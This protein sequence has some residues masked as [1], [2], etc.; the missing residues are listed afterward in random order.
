MK[1]KFF[2]LAA[3]IYSSHLHA[4]DSLST[5]ALD[6]V[7]VTAN[8]S[9]QKQS[10]TGKVISIISKT[11]IEKS[12]ARTLA[13]LLNDQAGITINGSL[14]NLGSNQTLYMRGAGQGRTLVLVDGVPVYDPS[15]ITSEFDLNLISLNE[16]ERV[17][18]C[19]GAQSTLY[20]SDA[21][22]GVINIITVNN[23]VTRAINTRAGI[24]FGNY[25]A[26]RANAQV[27]GKKNK[28]EYYARYSSLRNTGFSSAYDSTGNNNFDNDAYRGQAASAGIRYEL[29]K[30]LSARGYIQYSKYKNDLDAT[31]FTDEKDQTV[32]NRNILTGAEISYQRKRLLLF[33][34]YQYGTIARNYFND[35]LDIPGFTKFSTDD[36]SGKTQFVEFYS[37][38]KIGKNI[39]LIQGIDYRYS[40]MNSAFLSLSSFGPFT[41]E[42]SDT[43]HQQASV[44]ASA[45]Y[46]STNEKTSIELGGRFNNHS[47]Y[48]NNLTF[49]FN[50]SYKINAHFRVFGSVASAFKA[51]SLY[52]L[53]SG[54]GNK[55]LKPEYSTNYEIG[56]EQIHQ[57]IRNR[58]V[59]FHRDI[60]DGLDFDNLNFQYYNF[61]QQT[62]RGVEIES[63]IQ[64]IKN[65]TISINYTNLSFRENAQSRISF[66]DT[67]YNY[68]LRRP[69]HS[70]NITIGYQLLPSLFV[71][72]T[73]KHLSK[74]YDTGGYQQA[75]LLLNGY[76]IMNAYASYKFLSGFTLFIDIQNC[77]DRKFFDVRG[78]NSIPFLLQ[79]GLNWK[80]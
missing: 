58:V 21:V 59:Y 40:S 37:K 71:S 22:A 31:A 17:E 9:S 76:F 41:S 57:K 77:F 28:L 51:P 7:I 18:I 53:Y 50:P 39:S 70:A 1:K 2:V 61:Y 4:Q 3:L 52:Q 54:Y 5:A 35:S 78:Y 20:G 23:N 69:A 66:K 12:G 67:S 49:T 29:M 65:L 56:A 13:Q 36:Y 27:F 14:N 43:S 25:G 26:R 68:L 62:V 30:G 16:V 72:T 34:R 6:E 63:A 46:Q 8:K 15:L 73:G 33:G 38:L 32:S 10:S 19:K 47:R 75:D 80:W 74:R 45:I 64:P 11:Q 48:G 24:S 44:Y 79:T 42:F 55:E 60:R